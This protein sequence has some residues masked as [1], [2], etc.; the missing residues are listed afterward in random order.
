MKS[1]FFYQTDHTPCNV[2]RVDYLHFP[3]HL[4]KELEFIYVE[5]GSLTVTINEQTRVI[6]AGDFALV[7]PNVLH[8]YPESQSNVSA[9]VCICSPSLLGDFSS[10]VK[11]RHPE[12]PF[13]DHNLVHP[14]VTYAIGEL[15]NEFSLDRSSSVY[16]PLL[17]LVLA[18]TLPLCR[19]QK[20]VET[21]DSDLTYRIVSYLTQHYTQDLT[22][23][24]LANHLNISMYY[25]SHIFSSQFHMG[26][27]RYLNQLR[28][29]HA[30][31]LLHTTDLSILDIALDSGFSSQRTFNRVF[32]DFYHISPR[33]FRKRNTEK[34]TLADFT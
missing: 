14:N 18:R 23:A 33:E 22:L 7:F 5:H 16:S 24:S 30:I 10:T 11:H 1:S 12:V 32:L 25:V 26:F 21:S 4:H 9:I 8:S 3:M 19:L 13:L 17:Q 28:I 34:T 20:N 31:S 27:N 29:N 2:F 15:L 6:A